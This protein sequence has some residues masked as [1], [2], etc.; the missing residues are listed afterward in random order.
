MK[1]NGIEMDDFDIFD[2]ENAEKYEKAI[3]LLEYMQN[4]EGGSISEGIKEQCKIIFDFFNTVYG[5]GAD[6]KIFGNKV[7][8]LTC[9][10]ALGDFM[11]NVNDQKKEIEKINN[12]YSPDR[13]KR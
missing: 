6:K 5:D 3:E 4:I 7:N 13:L 12:K 9:I 10:K 11:T 1:L 8:L 2:V